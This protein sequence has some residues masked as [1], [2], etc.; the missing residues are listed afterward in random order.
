MCTFLGTAGKINE[1]DLD[2]NIIKKS[3]IIF[4]EGYL[5]DEGEPKK[6]FE[7]AISCS[8]KVAMSLSDVFCVERHKKQFLDLVKNKID[9]LFANE[10]E[11]MSLINCK[12]LSDII[13]FS[14]NLKSNVV[15]TRGKEGAI[16]IKNNEVQECPAKKNLKIIDLTGAGDLFAAGYLHGIIN[17]MNIK[18]SLF[19]GTEMSS[20][21][22]QQFGARLNENSKF[23]PLSIF[24]DQI[25]LGEEKKASLIDE[26]RN[27]KNNSQNLSYKEEND[28][29]TGDTQGHE[30]I[31]KNKK[32]D[33]FFGIKKKIDLYLDYLKIDTYQVEPFIQRS[34]ATISNGKEAINNHKHLQPHLSFAYYL[35]K[36][37]EDSK[38]VLQDEI[39]RNE[40][41]P[42]LFKSKSAIERKIIKQMS[43]STAPR[44][45]VEVKEND[46]VIFPSK[47]L[48][49]T[50]RNKSNNERISIS[51]DIS[52][53]SKDSNLLEHLTPSYENWKKL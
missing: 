32:F 24:Q 8:N 52:F 37:Q 47:T 10:Q 34:W 1:S 36:N 22:I 2:E 43:I 30:F 39:F 42:G 19:N 12:S 46:I 3:E 18:D 5:W 29:W 25:Y 41:I 40:F 49:G 27:M 50:E 51:G 21:I 53:L 44:V 4:L 31:H 35:K 20:K 48:H 33:I 15:I 45:S 6:A 23:F 13:T 14:K 11:I 17:N 9:I 26:V 16:S 28:S 7:K 38:F